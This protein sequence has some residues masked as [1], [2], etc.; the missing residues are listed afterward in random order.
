MRVIRW[1]VAINLGLVALQALSAGLFLSG[2]GS[3]V[4]L[5]RSGAIALQVV[6]AVQA[7]A[8]IVMWRRRRLPPWVAGASLGL[9]VVMFVQAGLGYRKL[10]WLHLPIGVGLF[11]G[12][13][14][15]M[16][17]LATAGTAAEPQPDETITAAS[18]RA[19]TPGS[20]SARSRSTP[21]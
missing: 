8:A 13:M 21:S 7:V 4:M 12:L 10:F 6:T 5:H 9:F 18:R 19:A 11:G 3:G 14:R 15:Q 20:V 16:N 1:L 2:Y 17:T